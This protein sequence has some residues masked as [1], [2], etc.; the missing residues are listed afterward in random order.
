[1]GRGV[2]A[3]PE[4]P[5]GGSRS[6][7]Q[8]RCTSQWAVASGSSLSKGYQ[9]RPF[10][11]ATQA[12]H[13]DGCSAPCN[14]LI[15]CPLQSTLPCPGPI[16]TCSWVSVC[17]CG[18]GPAPCVESRESTHPKQLLQKKQSQGSL[19]CLT[20]RSRSWTAGHGR[21]RREHGYAPPGQPGLS[22]RG[23]LL[24]RDTGIPQA[25]H[26]CKSYTLCKTGRGGLH[27]LSW[28][29]GFGTSSTLHAASNRS[30]VHRVLVS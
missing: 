7:F 24:Y 30:P 6:D 23:S 11:G 22:A 26:K 20:R 15:P 18:A 3:D 2:R 12:P 27:M 29:P 5:C 8:H 19:K 21:V 17:V 4:G 14:Y 25:P 13:P 28:V 10:D 1:M 9:W 16:G